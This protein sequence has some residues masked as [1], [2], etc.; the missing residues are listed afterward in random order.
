MTFSSQLDPG[1]ALTFKARVECKLASAAALGPSLCA[2]ELEGALAVVLALL[3]EPFELVVEA[4]DGSLLLFDLAAEGLAVSGATEE[5]ESVELPSP[6]VELP[7]C[8]PP[9]TL[10][11]LS[12]LADLPALEREPLAVGQGAAGVQ[13]VEGEGFGGGSAERLGEPVDGSVGLDSVR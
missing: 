13:R 12:S 5:A 11:L 8:F 4:R 6:P 7:F 2:S 1:V 9:F 10:D 3:L